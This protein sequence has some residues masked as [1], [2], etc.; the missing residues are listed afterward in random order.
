MTSLT[1]PAGGP[2][3]PVRYD[4]PS[5]PLFSQQWALQNTGQSGGVAG[6]DL[7]L[8]GVWGSYTGAGVSV[9]VVDDGVDYLHPDLD[10]GYDASLAISDTGGGAHDPYPQNADSAHGTAVAGLIAGAENGIGTVGVAPEARFAGVDIFFD[11]QM[12]EAA[13][14]NALSGFDVSNH[15][16]GYNARY[17]ANRLSGDSFWTRFFDGIEDSVQTGRGGLGTVNVIAA[18]NDRSATRDANDSNFTNLPET[19]AVTAVGHDGFVSYYS[20]PG[21]SV[22]VSAPSSGPSGSGIW[23]TDR[24]GADGYSDG[25]NEPGNTEPNYT[26]DFGGTSAAAPQVAGVVALLLEANPQ[27]GWRDVQEILA[28]SARQVGS[29]LGSGPL[30]NELYAWDVNAAQS[31]NGGG[32]HFSNDY[33]FGLVD[34]AAALALA[35]TWNKQQT[36]GNW[37]AV[38]ADSWTGTA[39]VP[40]NDPTGLTI[41]FDAA[42]QMDLDTVGITIALQDAWWSDHAL[43]LTAP[44]GTVS[45]LSRGGGGG[46]GEAD[47]WLF[48]SHAFRGEDSAGTWTL[49][50]EDQWAQDQATLTQA[51]LTFW[52]DA[53]SADDLYIVTEEYDTLAGGVFGHGTAFTDTDGGT[54]TLN[55]AILAADAVVDLAAGTGRLDGV[56]VTLSGIE[57][58]YTG[59]GDDRLIGTADGE[60]L[61]AGVGRDRL[62]GR[63]GADLL[64]GGAGRDRAL[65]TD[66]QT[67]VNVSLVRGEVARKGSAEGDQLTSIEEV[68]GSAH[69][70]VLT[71]NGAK[72]VLRGDDSGDTLY[73]LGKDDKLFG[74]QGFDHLDGGAGNDL[75]QGGTGKDTLIG[76]TGDDTLFGEEHD[77][78]L[79]GGAG[80][81]ILT[82]GKGVDVFVFGLGDDTDTITDFED[83]TDA[84]EL[85]D[86]LWGGGLTETEVLAAHGAQDGADVIL[87]FGDAILVVQTMT[88]SALENDLVFV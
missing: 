78:R 51:E 31:W 74:Q 3:T 69:R 79:L 47:S 82:G 40:D 88:L 30:G 42:A 65:Y 67:G 22:L 26:S 16:W 64:D 75:L 56:A 83:D 21:A 2:A 76:G 60:T 58:V 48:T 50:I 57:T 53:A 86:A 6:I 73:G 81:D 9:A 63:D 59:R 80:S 5:D 84:I 28:A 70:D 35:E 71:G 43:T 7:N 55:A 66:S 11:G 61:V 19:I 45:V 27:L 87:N 8:A 85:A 23:T 13:A 14:A 34:A 18:G 24:Q 10:D 20:T 49:K 62:Q 54:D 32:Y 39:V 38:D 37:L 46:K 33:G 1:K 36:S 29:P 68:R 15:S 25:G 52:G 41:S 72:N 12:D 4:L 17:I 77:D 44:S